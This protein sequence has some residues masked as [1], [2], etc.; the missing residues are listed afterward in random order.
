MINR[1]PTKGVQDVTPAE[2]WHGLKPSVKHLKVFGAIAYAHIP[3]QTRNKLDNRAEKT[4]IVGY[5]DGAY[6]LFNPLSKKVI[7][8]RDATFAEGETWNW[9]SEHHTASKGLDISSEEDTPNAGE[10]N[11]SSGQDS[12]ISQ[13]RATT[14]SG[15]PRRNH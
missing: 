4:I 13:E 2:A 14:D 9:N 10:E 1:S 8:S 11:V 7:V 5:K 3:K 12:P 15:R 6:K